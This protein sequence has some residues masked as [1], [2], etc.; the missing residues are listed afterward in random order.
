[1]YIYILSKINIYIKSM[2][3]DTY[4][5]GDFYKAPKNANNDYSL[6]VNQSELEGKK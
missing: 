5:K 3:Q 1:M 4:T 6:S 2:G